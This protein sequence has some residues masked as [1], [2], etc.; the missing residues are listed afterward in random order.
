[1]TQT[2]IWELPP[3][4]DIDG[5]ALQIE[6]SSSNNL[7]KIQL[8]IHMIE[9]D[10]YESDCL[11]LITIWWKETEKGR[12]ELKNFWINSWS[13]WS[14]CWNKIWLLSNKNDYYNPQLWDNIIVKVN[15]ENNYINELFLMNGKTWNEITT[16][17]NTLKEPYCSGWITNTET[18]IK[19]D[20]FAP[21]SPQSHIYNESIFVWVLC[22]FLII[23]WVLNLKLYKKKS[24]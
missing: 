13:T 18:E 1:M 6:K 8:K 16:F 21:L 10:Y 20:V 17:L 23:I 3:Q 24:P 7:C 4:S 9:S 19:N 5:L 14:Y 22:I 2:F 12:I 11:S 15:S